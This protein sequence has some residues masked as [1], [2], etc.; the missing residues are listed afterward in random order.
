MAHPGP[1]R[2]SD[3]LNLPRRS[4]RGRDGERA[5]RPSPGLEDDWV[6]GCPWRC[7]LDPGPAVGQGSGR[8]AASGRR[9][10]WLRSTSVLSSS[11][12][13]SESEEKAGWE[14]SWRRC[15]LPR[16][17]HLNL[18]D[19]PT[20]GCCWGW[21]KPSPG[22][23]GVGAARATLPRVA[24]AAVFTQ[25]PPHDPPR[26]WTRAGPTQKEGTG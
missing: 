14:A 6:L 11:H 2:W 4:L 19:R 18:E 10:S 3:T 16:H 5:G 21:D 24:V 20:S 15:L 25:M 12:T 23:A 7:F 1:P 8:E 26:G 9:K 22:M 17:R 13:R